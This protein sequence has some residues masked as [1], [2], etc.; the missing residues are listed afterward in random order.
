MSILTRTASR[1]SGIN[2]R[3]R[4]NWL[5]LGAFALAI[6][7]IVAAILLWEHLSFNQVGYAGI[8]IA[9]IIASAGFII[10]VPALATVCST[11]TTLNPLYIGLIAGSGEALGELTGY[12][13]GFSGR[14]VIHRNNFYLRLETWMRQRGWLVLFLVSLI[15]NPFFDIIGVAAGALRFPIWGFLLVVWVGKLIKFIVFAYACAFS[16]E[17]LTSAFG[18]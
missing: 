13:L 16:I 5:R 8:A 12:F 6:S 11:S 2:W 18:A 7:L 4:E 9:S 10:P 15:P 14:G 1:V 17:W 3:S